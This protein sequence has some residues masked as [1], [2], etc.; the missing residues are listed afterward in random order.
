MYWDARSA[1]RQKK[2]RG[3]Y[4]ILLRPETCLNFHIPNII[5]PFWQRTG[6]WL[7]AHKFASPV[8]INTVVSFILVGAAS[9]LALT[10]SASD[11]I[12]FNPSKD[13][14]QQRI[15]QGILDFRNIKNVYGKSLKVI[16]ITRVKM[17]ELYPPIFTKMTSAQQRYL[18][19]G[20]SPK[21]ENNYRTLE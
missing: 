17:F 8:F 7:T 2:G 15:H 11:L 19:F 18:L 14:W 4:F 12:G 10:K 9:E 13:E 6:W 5:A 16:T 21:L 1:K 3:C 20:M